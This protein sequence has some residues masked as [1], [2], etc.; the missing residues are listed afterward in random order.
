MSKG[1]IILAAGAASGMGKPKMLLPFSTTNILT[2][3]IQEAK[4]VH[5]DCLCIVSGFYHEEILR[6]IDGKGLDIVYNENWKEGMAGSIKKGLTALLRKEPDLSSVLLLLGDQPYLNGIVLEEMY[7][8]YSNNHKGIVAARYGSVTGP[9]ALFDKKYFSQ[10][11]ELKGDTGAKS[12][13]QQNEADCSL[14]DF[15]LGA[16]DIDTPEDYENLCFQNG[17]KHA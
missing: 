12:I 16:I 10:L 17:K 6:N 9:P 5:P 3:I 11:L 2:H 15:P 1:V 8:L 14:I 13:L 4:S 7:A